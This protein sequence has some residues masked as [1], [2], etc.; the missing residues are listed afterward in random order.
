MSSSEN[1]SNDNT[2]HLKVSGDM[3]GERVPVL[4]KEFETVIA[5][6]P[7]GANVVLDLRTVSHIDSRGISLCVGIYKKCAKRNAVLS[8]Q[9]G[10]ESFRILTQIKLDKIIRIQMIPDERT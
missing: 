4:E 2:V 1:R 10:G 5:E 9:A 8:I 7:K 3:S 6:L